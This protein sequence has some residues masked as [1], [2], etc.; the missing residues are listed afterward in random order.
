MNNT[1]TYRTAPTPRSRWNTLILTLLFAI[2][3]QTTTAQGVEEVWLNKAVNLL[4]QKGVEVVFR[5]NE[6]GMR[7][8]G[9]LLMSGNK[10][11]FD[12]DQMKVWFDGNLQYTLQVSNDYSELYINTPTLDEQQSINPYLLLMHYNH[13]FTLSDGGE[14]NLDGKLV[15]KVILTAKDDTQ[16]LSGV[17]VYIKEDGELLELHLIFP[18]DRSYR[19]EVRSMRYGLTFPNHTFIYSEKDYPVDEIIDMR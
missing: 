12:T 18:D 10:F 3:S 2:A 5:I 4:Q 14:K 13:N 11:M 8:G 16:E 17:N 1:M 6:D 19:I 9:K 7:L 15:H